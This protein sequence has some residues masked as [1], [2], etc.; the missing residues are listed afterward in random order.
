MTIVYDG[1]PSTVI[2]PS[3]GEN[4][5][6]NTDDGALV[7]GE[8]HGAAGWY[9]VNDHPL[10]KAAYTFR[11]TVPAGLQVDRQRPPAGSHTRTAGRRGCG[12]RPTRWPPT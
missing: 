8:P 10:D 6:F 1:V 7:A 5:F 11:I 3:L 12:M 4:G 9:P 2:E